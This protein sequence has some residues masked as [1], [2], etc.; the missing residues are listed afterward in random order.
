MRGQDRGRGKEGLG[1][2]QG[3]R[4]GCDAT[5][6]VSSSFVFEGLRHRG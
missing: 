5:D 3:D 4:G 1:P 6:C 2:G